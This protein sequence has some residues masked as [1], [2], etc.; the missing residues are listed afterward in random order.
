MFS[1]IL[2]QALRL[3]PRGFFLSGYFGVREQPGRRGVKN[4]A[5]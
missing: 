1:W 2:I 4:D 3:V 5:C